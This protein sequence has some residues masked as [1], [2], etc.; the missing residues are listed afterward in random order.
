M[1]GEQSY[2]PPKRSKVL[3]SPPRVRGT[4]D[5]AVQH[6][7][8]DRITPAC[9]GNRKMNIFSAW[10]N[11]D[12]PRVC[13]EQAGITVCTLSLKGSPP[14]VRGTVDVYNAPNVFI[15]ITPA[16]AGNSGGRA[17]GGGE[18]PDH[19][20]VC[21]EQQLLHVYALQGRG[22]PPRVRGTAALAGKRAHI[23]GITPA[24]AGNSSLP[25]RP[26]NAI[27][28]HPRVC[29]EQR[30]DFASEVG[31]IGSPPRVR[32]TVHQLFREN[33]SKGITP[34]CAGNSLNSFSFSG[35]WKDHPRVCGE[36]T[37]CAGTLIFIKG[38]PP[39]VRGTDPGCWQR[40]LLLGITP[41]CAG[42]SICK[43]IQSH[44]P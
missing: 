30:F 43:S 39:R 38:S 40:R 26:N 27:K 4:G 22:S 3:G 34:A 9:A 14:R 41:A 33:Y 17:G 1:C 42:N 15:G 6:R 31:G 35:Y 16:C 18:A 21:G 20:R 7:P 36:Q 37:S 28:D 12:H 19:P 10:P 13:G 32:G 44:T 24:C 23:V 11:W 25:T 8:R 5:I 29:G 2:F